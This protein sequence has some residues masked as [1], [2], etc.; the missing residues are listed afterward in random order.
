M[1]AEDLTTCGYLPNGRAVS[2]DFSILKLYAAKRKDSVLGYF[3]HNSWRFV[4]F[5]FL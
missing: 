3:R 1:T 2:F 5:T 4:D